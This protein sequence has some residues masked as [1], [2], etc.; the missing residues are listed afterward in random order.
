MSDRR[1]AMTMQNQPLATHILPV[2]ATMI[3]VCVTFIG[4]IKLAEDR[5]GWSQVDEYAALVSVV[6]LAS[7][8]SSYLSIRYAK[9]QRMSARIERIADIVFLA[10]LVGITVVATLFAYEVI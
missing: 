1:L 10:G 6:F 8:L 5:I 4:L 3:G 2:S 9:L 7:A